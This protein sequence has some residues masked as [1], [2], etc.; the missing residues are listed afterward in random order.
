M[1]SRQVLA[2]SGPLIVTLSSGMTVGFSAVLLPQLKDDRSTIK[3]G[4]HQESWIGESDRTVSVIVQRTLPDSRWSCCTNTTV[5]DGDIGRRVNPLLYG[6]VVVRISFSKRAVLR[7]NASVGFPFH[8]RVNSY[9]IFHTVRLIVVIRYATRDVRSAVD[10]FSLSDWIHAYSSI[11]LYNYL[12][13]LRK[14]KSNNK[15]QLN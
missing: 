15:L 10:R 8:I 5:R 1:D 2:A 9:H 4:S 11:Q 13:T 6:R 3:I 12:K 7:V 14:N